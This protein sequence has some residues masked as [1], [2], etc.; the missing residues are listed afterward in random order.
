MNRLSAERVHQEL[1][2]TMEQVRRPARAFALWKSSGVLATVIPPLAAIEDETIEALDC[3][4]MPTGSKPGRLFERVA[5]LFVALGEAEARASLTAL[6]FSRS[7]L[8]RIT[9]LA[10]IWNK[11]T[12]P[13]SDVVASGRMPPDEDVRRWLSIIGRLNLVAFMR[14]VVALHGERRDRSQAAAHGWR[15]LYRR[16]L[17]S[18]RRD[19]I[20]IADLVIDGDDLGMAGIVAGPWVGKILQALLDAVLVDPSRNERDWLLQEARRLYDTMRPS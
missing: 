19:P 1:Q 20:E 13:M 14:I 9:D 18:A 10:R 17:I 2:K 15:R 12:T 5:L 8:R 11:V 3:I 16:M 6:R 7:E 4:P